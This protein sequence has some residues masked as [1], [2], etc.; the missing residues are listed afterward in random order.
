MDITRDF[1]YLITIHVSHNSYFFIYYFVIVE[2]AL[3]LLSDD[4]ETRIF[5]TLS[6]GFCLLRLPN[7]LCFAFSSVNGAL[8]SDPPFVSVA[9][10]KIVV[11]FCAFSSGVVNFLTLGWYMALE[12]RSYLK[13][14]IIKITFSELSLIY[15][16]IRFY[17]GP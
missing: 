14:N 5:T 3:V 17:Q 9:P 10:V 1:Y 7:R 8:L 2:W 4:L 11:A 6:C 12:G 15:S 16:C 13:I